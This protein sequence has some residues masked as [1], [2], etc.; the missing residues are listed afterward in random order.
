MVVFVIFL[1][2]LGEVVGLFL[3]FCGKFEGF[4]ENVEVVYVVCDIFVWG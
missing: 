3:V 4:G 2:Y 1:F